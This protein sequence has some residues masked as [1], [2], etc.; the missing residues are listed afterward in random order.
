MHIIHK[1]THI[2]RVIEQSST[3]SNLMSPA[4]HGRVIVV[5]MGGRC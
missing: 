5:G 1:A 4:W 2:H 3:P